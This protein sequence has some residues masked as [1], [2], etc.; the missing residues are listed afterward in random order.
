VGAVSM[1]LAIALTLYSLFIYMR[2][3]G[4]LFRVPARTTN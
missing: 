1:L 4:Y 2:D 3:Y